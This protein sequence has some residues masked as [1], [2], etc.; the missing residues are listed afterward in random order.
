MLEIAAGD[1]VVPDVATELL[2]VRAAH[3]LPELIV[4]RARELVKEPVAL[5]VVDLDGAYLLRLAGEGV[6]LPDRFGA[7]LAV[8]T[9]LPVEAIDAVRELIRQAAP[10][11]DAV[12]LVVRDR[13][14][15]VLVTTRGAAAPLEQFATQAAM[16]LEMAAGY[17]DVVHAARRRK[18]VNP[19]A[20]IQQNLL[21]PRIATLS[22]YQ[23]AGGV[24]PGYEIGGDFFDY[25]DNPDGIWIALGDAA[26]K[27]TRAAALSSIAIGALRAAR[28]SGATL[29]ETARLL[30]DT[31]ASYDGDL[32]LTAVLAVCRSD[33]TVGWISAG[34]PYPL[35]VGC[36]GAARELTDG[37]TNPLGL[38]PQDLHLTLGHTRLA[39]GEQLVLYSDGVT[40]RKLASGAR[41]GPDKLTQLFRDRRPP[42]PSATVRAIHSMVIDASSEPLH[43]DATVLAVGRDR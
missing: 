7:P 36:D 11:L 28:R 41:L 33:G 10:D 14:L 6:A 20:E 5:Y 37:Q 32:Y 17:T 29:P 8:G 26:G 1:G 42:T 23:V 4:A 22:G 3:R 38:F 18:P 16:A 2:D 25:A 40:E 31:I 9:E 13:A 19:A 21:P 30:H 35:H 24:L 15:G 27:G 39:V 12:P 43:D 34:H